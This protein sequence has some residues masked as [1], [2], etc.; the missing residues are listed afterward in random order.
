M[1]CI[2]YCFNTVTIT[3][4]PRIAMQ[5]CTPSK[6]GMAMGSTRAAR[7]KKSTVLH[8]IPENDTKPLGPPPG[9]KPPVAPAN[10]EVAMEGPGYTLN[11]AGVL[12]RRL[13]DL[14]RAEWLTV[15][16]KRGTAAEK[17]HGKSL[18]DSTQKE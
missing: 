11:P 15:I 1:H 12:A 10:R 17:V 3:D 9:L 14:E 18:E 6:K 2:S 4:Y 5:G 13:A 7:R 8:S 16:T